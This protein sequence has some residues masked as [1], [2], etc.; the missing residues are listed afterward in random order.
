M[1]RAYVAMGDPLR[2]LLSLERAEH[3]PATRT[4]ARAAEALGWVTP[5]APSAAARALRAIGAVPVP[6][7][8]HEPTWGALAFEPGGKLLVRTAA[9]AVRVDPDQGDEAAA[10]GVEWKPAV[11]SPEG[12][13][14]WIE[15][16]DPCDGLPLRASFST[17]GGDDLEGPGPSGPPAASRPLRR[18]QGAPARAIPMAWGPRG[19]EAI[20]EGEP[21][22]IAS[23]LSSASPLAAF[24]D[25][26]ATRGSPRSP[27]GKSD[28]VP[29]EAGLL[30]RGSNRARLLRAHELEATYAD[31]HACVVSDDQTHVACIRADKAWVGQWDPP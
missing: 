19:L 8:G 18:L 9:G 1:V 20:V 31:Q 23:D 15:T 10:G 13:L 17:G 29:T 27:D 4:P 22:L 26:P 7:H 2:A 24:L 28:V 21:V 25:Q 30:V 16:Y 14:R 12:A 6:P 11:T 3:A 5:L